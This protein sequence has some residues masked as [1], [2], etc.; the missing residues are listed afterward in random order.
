M[1]E[2]ENRGLAREWKDIVQV[3]PRLNPVEEKTFLKVSYGKE[4]LDIDKA[5]SRK[6]HNCPPVI[7][8]TGMPQVGKTTLIAETVELFKKLDVPY[9]IIEEKGVPFDTDA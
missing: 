3:L 1:D 9:H 4:L 5:R 2:R 7:E 8:I 6:T